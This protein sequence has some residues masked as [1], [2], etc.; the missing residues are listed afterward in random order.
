MAYYFPDCWECGMAG[1]VKADCPDAVCVSCKSAAL[2]AVS[3]NTRVEHVGFWPIKI[4][5]RAEDCSLLEDFVLRRAAETAAWARKE[6][7]KRETAVGTG[8]SIGPFEEMRQEGLRLRRE[9]QRARRYCPWDAAELEQR[10]GHDRPRLLLSSIIDQMWFW[11]EQRLMEVV[12]EDG[13]IKCACCR[14][15]L[16]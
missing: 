13:K 3:A 4:R 14:A 8:L 6:G 12:R 16:D 9:E 5:I 2:F 11:K 10:L 7:A 15:V 1:H